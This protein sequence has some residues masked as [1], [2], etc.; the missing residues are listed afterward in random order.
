MTNAFHPIL[1]R[2]CSSDLD[3]VTQIA[4]SAM[5]YAWSRAVF[6]DCL[7]AQYDSWVLARKDAD[8]AILGFAVVLVELDECQ[9]MN[10][11]IKPSYQRQGYGK[12]ML[13][14]VIEYSR[15]KQLSRVLLEVRS[16]NT[17]AI[18]LYKQAGFVE[19]GL[20]KQYYASDNGREDALIFVKGLS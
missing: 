19:V 5:S 12:L 20:R 10:I 9:L 6:E 1:R 17:A 15:A 18:A 11:C 16:S 7:K 3:A 4:A 2:L 13:E 14:H 8:Q